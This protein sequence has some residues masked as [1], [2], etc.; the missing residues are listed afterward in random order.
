MHYSIHFSAE[1]KQ[2][3]R[4]YKEKTKHYSKFYHEI[5]LETI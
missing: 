1:L 2:V 4:K 5:D 3:C